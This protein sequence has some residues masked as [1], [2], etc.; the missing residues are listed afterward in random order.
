MPAASRFGFL[1]G[2]YAR[3][4]T[5]ALILESLVYYTALGRENIPRIEPL[6]DFPAYLQGWE[7]LQNVPIEPEILNVLR[8]DDT[9]NRAYARAGTNEPAHLFIAFFK[10]QR[11]NQAPHSPKNCLPGSGWEASQ[12]G[13]IDIQVPDR[14]SPIRI[15]RYVVAR[16][17][18]KGVVLYWYQSRNRIVASEYAAKFW[19]VADAI[20]Y[21]RSDTTLVRI[22][23]PVKENDVEGATQSGI[24]FLQAAFPELRRRLPA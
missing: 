5:C 20:R 19:L 16:G 9:L 24:S 14:P 17:E 23:V 3:V 7:L 12:E 10:T 22:W 18:A 15:N 4:L 6:S 21:H 11:A 2:G 13:V 8:A 1:S